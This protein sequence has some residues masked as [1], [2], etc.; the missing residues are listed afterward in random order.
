MAGIHEIRDM[1]P[2][3]KASALLPGELMEQLRSQVLHFE[4]LVEGN[5]QRMAQVEA[6]LTDLVSANGAK[7]F[8]EKDCPEKI[9]K[10]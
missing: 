9:V 6:C 2:K 3:R 4:Q 10:M 5:R 7:Y 1:T 8:Q